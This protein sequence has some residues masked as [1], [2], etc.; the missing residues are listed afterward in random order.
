MYVGKYSYLCTRIT[1]YMPERAVKVV[2]DFMEKASYN[3]LF[4]V[5]LNLR[6][7]KLPIKNIAEWMLRRGIKPRQCAERIG[8]PQRTL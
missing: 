5:P 4:L 2:G 1:P 3:A 8:Y 6:N 7:S